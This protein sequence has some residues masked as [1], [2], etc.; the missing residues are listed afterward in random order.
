LDSVLSY[1][2]NFILVITYQE[3]PVIRVLFNLL[4]YL[5]CRTGSEIEKYLVFISNFIL[6]FPYLR[7]FFFSSQSKA[8]FHNDCI[9]P[10]LQSFI[11]LSLNTVASPRPTSINSFLDLQLLTECVGERNGLSLTFVLITNLMRN[12]FIL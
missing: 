1:F 6:F 8:L 11:F 7:D 5:I 12:S 2:I 4:I 10:H 3:L 9:F